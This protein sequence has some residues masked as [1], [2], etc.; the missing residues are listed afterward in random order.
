M[1]LI[2]LSP[3]LRKALLADAATCGATGV[4]LMLGATLLDGLLGVPAAFN[5]YAG[6]ALLPYGVLLASLATR[7]SLPRPVVWSVVAGNLLW[8]SHSVLLLLAGWITPTAFG[9]EV[10]IAQALVVAIFAEAQYFGLRR[11]LA[12]GAENSAAGRT[13]IVEIG[14]RRTS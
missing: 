4:V 14:P 11:S 2:H 9:R 12:A 3:F 6:L 5:S 1:S 13:G 10:I 8:S 7:K